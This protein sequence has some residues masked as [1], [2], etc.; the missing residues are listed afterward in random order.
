[1]WEKEGQ[2]MNDPMKEHPQPEQLAGFVHHSL[3]DG[4]WTAVEQHVSSCDTCRQILESLPEDPLISLVRATATIASP[5]IPPLRLH[6]GYE[7]LEEIGQG[8]MGV[9]YKARQAA[10]NRLVALKRIHAG[11]H[12]RPEALARFHREA[13]AAARLDHPNIVQIYEVGEQDGQPY[14]ALEYV[15]GGTLAGRLAG[16]PLVPAVAAEL[17]ETLA[18]AI[19]YAH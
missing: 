16:T 7:I 3:D 5:N 9:V 8:G 4:E 13:A 14:L 2:P 6:A 10:L 17:V 19:A 18:R 11:H 1:M 15:D 12:T